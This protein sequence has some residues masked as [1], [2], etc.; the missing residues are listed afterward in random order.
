M[1]CEHALDEPGLLGPSEVDPVVV[2]GQPKGSMYRV[3][4]LPDA[5]DPKEHDP[6]Q[7]N[8]SGGVGGDLKPGVRGQEVI[9]LDTP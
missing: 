9:A 1:H 3:S 7:V 8:G 4:T 2:I 6:D 5:R